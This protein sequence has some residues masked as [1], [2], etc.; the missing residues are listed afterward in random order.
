MTNRI[1]QTWA[2]ATAPLRFFTAFAS[3][4][5]LVVSLAMTVCSWAQQPVPL[6]KVGILS[7][8]RSSTAVCGSDAA[9][10]RCFVEGLRALGYVDGRNVSLEYRFADGDYKRLPALAAELVSLSPDVIY[11]HTNA[12]ADAAARATTTI[13]IVVGPAGE[14]ALTR[15]AVNLARPTGNVT[16][17][18]LNSS[19]QDQ[20]CLQLLKDLAPR[21]SRVAVLANPDNPAYRDYPGVLGAAATKLDVTLIRI[22][23]R[24]VFDLPQAFTAIAESRA[25]AVFMVDD[26]A[27]AGS[28]EVRKQVIEWA[29]VRRLPIASSHAGVA[30]DGGLVSLGTDFLALVRRAAFYVDKILKGAKPSDLPVERPTTYK[31]SVNLKTAKALGI[32]IPQSVLLRADEVIQ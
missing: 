22:G 21:T 31:L 16:G 24:R 19:Q 10:A 27:L 13:P 9:G 1:P 11:T 29:L 20:K 14:G 32:T 15:L 18:T 5:L 12:G 2:R 23:A 30:S 4:S 17:V 28:V 26:A 6:P 8:G 25:D 3:A 7:P